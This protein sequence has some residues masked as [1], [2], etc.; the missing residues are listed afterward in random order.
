[1]TVSFHKFG[2]MFFPGT[3][4]IKDV[5]ESNGRYYSL[6][7]PLKDGCTD[8]VFLDLFK[9]VMTKVSTGMDLKS[10]HFKISNLKPDCAAQGPGV[11]LGRVDLFRKTDV[12]S[13]YPH[14]SHPIISIDQNFG[15][16]IALSP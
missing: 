4:D 12:F 11:C 13:M 1:M 10:V 16:C 9:S 15:R 3:G 6:N 2:D 8:K 5:G 14:Y 7:V